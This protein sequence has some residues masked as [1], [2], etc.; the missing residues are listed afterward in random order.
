[1]T[2][3]IT[4]LVKAHG[5]VLLAFIAGVLLTFAAVVTVNTALAA[6][7]VIGPDSPTLTGSNAY[8]SGTG[9]ASGLTNL[10]LT[11]DYDATALDGDAS[12][13][14]VYGWKSDLTNEEVVLDTISGESGDAPSGS[15]DVD[16]PTS[17]QVS[18]LQ[19]FASSSVDAAND[20]VVITNLIVSGEVDTGSDPTLESVSPA[21]GAYEITLGDNFVWTVYA[22]DVDGDLYELEIDH[23]LEGTIPEFSVYASATDP[24]GGDE[25]EFS[26][27][28]VT[29]TYDESEQSWTIDFG[30][31]VTDLFVNNGITFFIVL[32]DNEG[33]QFGSMDPT[34]SDNTFAYTLTREALDTCE[35][36]DHSVDSGSISN[37]DT[38]EEFDTIQN[39]IDDCDTDD[40]DTIE[41]N[42]TTHE[43]DVNVT[44]SVTLDGLGR[45]ATINGQITIQSEGVT[46]Q[47]FNLTNPG[48]L[49]AVL[50]NGYGTAAISGNSFVNVGSEAGVSG[51]VHAFWFQD[52]L[53]DVSDIS[54][55][56]NIFDT[57][58]HAQ[59]ASASAIGIGDSTGDATITDV[60]ISGNNISNVVAKHDS[61]YSNG[62]RG[63]YGIILNHADAGGGHDGAVIDA[64]ITDNTINN[65]EGL[66]VHA[67]GL[68]GNT[69]NAVVT[70]NDISD[71]FE[72]KL[73]LEG[74]Q[75][76]I[77]VF[78]EDNAS[79]ASV[80]ISGN[81]FVTDSSWF[82]VAVH[83]NE[84][85]DYILDAEENWWNTT[86]TSTIEERIY[87]PDGI[88]IDY[89][90][91]LCEEAPSSNISEDGSCD[92]VG[93]EVEEEEESSSS[94]SGGTRT[95][96]G[97][98]GSN[99]NGAPTPQVLGVSTSA[100]G[101]CGMLLTTYMSAGMANNTWEV[102]K[103]QAFLVG[104][105][106]FSVKMTGVFDAE[107]DA[108]VKLYQAAH[109]EEILQPWIDAGLVTE[110]PPN[111][112]VYSFT[113]WHINNTV[114][115][116]GEM[117]P[118]LN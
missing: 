85:G 16:L 50:L 32:K 51:T 42:G 44:K 111:G 54:I 61:N 10:T 41:V 112:N 105:G 88:T 55:T 95:R 63:V 40:G 115:P 11:F 49:K 60:T 100:V 81:N 53:D 20:E 64:L 23:S 9:D 117:R 92:D 113:R 33:N 12:D 102:M 35:G 65:L 3:N 15:V 79:A 78:I 13:Q 28:G 89:E 4:D 14:F 22:D 39:A 36:P 83:P 114:C 107:T 90:P 94:S 34:T 98:G 99:N 43:E 57:I 76:G 106:Y 46:I 104:Q 116:G 101:Q 7:T 38:G 27:A 77:G 68:E 30:E 21:A 5:K 86:S 84:V 37:T 103:L 110:L 47:N 82:G 25:A 87:A 70:G 45:S 26:A 74:V 18:D 73:A 56:N 31:T 52:G 108:A 80:S 96:G 2:H 97:S 1:M 72:H 109:S 59:G 67:I 93:E 62:G 6:T 8:E 75:D 118:V 48:G 17:A 19:I 91:W 71:L 66:W 24:Y 29:V 69:P 58:G